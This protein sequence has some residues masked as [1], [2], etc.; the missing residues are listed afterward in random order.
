LGK[1]PQKGFRLE[2]DKISVVFGDE[3]GPRD[4]LAASTRIFCA[5]DSAL[6]CWRMSGVRSTN[7]TAA[8]KH[9]QGQQKSL[10]LSTG[11]G[12]ELWHL[13]AGGELSVFSNKIKSV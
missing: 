10:S 9:A 5:L 1:K 7:S 12:P 11:F 6:F 13:S 4:K 2:T 3:L 8:H